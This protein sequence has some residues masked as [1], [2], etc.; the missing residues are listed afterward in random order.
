MFLSAGKN[1]P[2]L[3]VLDNFIVS[4]KENI[5]KTLN[6]YLDQFFLSMDR[7]FVVS[8]DFIVNILTLKTE[9]TRGSSGS[10]SFPSSNA[11]RTD[12]FELFALS[13]NKFFD[14]GSLTVQMNRSS[15]D[16][17]YDNSN[18]AFPVL[19]EHNL[20]YTSFGLKG[21]QLISE[22]LNYEATFNQK[23]ELGC[24]VVVLVDVLKKKTLKNIV[25][26]SVVNN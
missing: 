6:N 18:S 1:N 4:F 7:Q 17:V 20:D 19:S 22:S 14:K 9:N 25:T 12:D 10:T 23:T 26:F 2:T 8:D 15:N 21:K 13:F 24:M 3:K 16:Q 5:I 11:T